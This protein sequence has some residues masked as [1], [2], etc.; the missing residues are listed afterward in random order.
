MSEQSTFADG[1]P[2]RSRLV[3]GLLMVGA[4]CGVVYLAL[5][6]IP[7]YHVEFERDETGGAIEFLKEIQAFQAEYL[8]EHG[9]YLGDEQWAEWPP[10]AFPSEDGVAWGNPTV[11]AWA[12]LPVRLRPNEP[13][14]FKFR[15]RASARPELA[16]EGLVSPLSGPWYVAQARADLDGDQVLWLIEVSSTVHAVYIENDGE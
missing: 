4:L 3:R 2:P 9:R 8:L 5:M 15:L 12:R 16:I 6:F 10:G 11:G 1:A 7:V 14:R 13:V